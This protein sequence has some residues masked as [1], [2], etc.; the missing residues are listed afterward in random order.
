MGR[1]L[2]PPPFRYLATS[3]FKLYTYNNDDD[4]NNNN[5]RRRHDQTLIRI[6]EFLNEHLQWRFDEDFFDLDMRK[7]H[8]SHFILRL[9]YCTS[10]DQRRSVCVV[11]WCVLLLL[12]LLLSER[13]K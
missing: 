13:R 12:L 2:T 10:E 7:D 6:T 8:V 5:H 3:R 4:K 11:C 1:L 9:A